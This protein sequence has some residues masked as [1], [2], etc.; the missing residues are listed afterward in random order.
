[1]PRKH[2]TTLG[3]PPPLRRGSEAKVS[4][5]GRKKRAA[6]TKKHVLFDIVSKFVA[7]VER[8]ETQGQSCHAKQ[9]PGFAPLNPG[10]AVY[11]GPRKGGPIITSDSLMGF[12]VAR[13]RRA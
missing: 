10:Y 8:S 6:G 1:M 2:P 3:A 13:R 4:K 11:L 12:A 9:T 5:P 7:W